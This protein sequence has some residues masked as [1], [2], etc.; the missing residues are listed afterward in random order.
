MYVQLLDKPI[1]CSPIQKEG[2]LVAVVGTF[3]GGRALGVI[4]AGFRIFNKKKIFL[5]FFFKISLYLNL[6]KRYCRSFYRTSLCAYFVYSSKN[7][8]F[9][10]ER[11]F[12][13]QEKLTSAN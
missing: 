10:E 12:A 2:Y 4:V 3:V 13:I 5:Q 7:K 1:V 8:Y 11:H 9:T 6:K